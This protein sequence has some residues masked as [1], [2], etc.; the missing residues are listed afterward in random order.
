M[1]GKTLRKNKVIKLN[2][3]FMGG[4]TSITLRKDVVAL[5]VLMLEHGGDDT[6]LHL[7]DFINDQCLE[8]WNK[9][10]AVGLSEFINWCLIRS[11]LSQKDFFSWRK[12]YK[13]L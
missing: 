8:R 4:M 10:S 5:W 12:I 7:K 2:I 11:F 1:N 9:D 6:M 3:K 13:S